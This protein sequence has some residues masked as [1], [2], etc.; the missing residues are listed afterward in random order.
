MK[1]KYHG[2]RLILLF[3][4]GSHSLYA[5]DTL[6]MRSL[7]ERVGQLQC[8]DSR[9]FPKGSIPCYRTYA[10]NKDRSKADI[11][12]FY[13][14]LTTFTLRNLKGQLTS[15]QQALCEQIINQTMPV[16][17]KFK[18]QKGRTTYNFWPTDTPQIFPHAGWI[19]FFDKA[20]SLPDDLDDTVIML[21][22][23]QAADSTAE[24][25]HALMQGYTNNGRKQIRN[26]F[27]D[28]RKIGAYSTW[29][30]KKM[31]VD[32][33][34][35]VLAN[36]LY[37][38]QSYDLA[39][40]SADSASLQLMVKILADK[41]HITHAAYVS[42]HYSRLPNI[43]YHISRLMQVKPIPELEA[44]KPALVEEALFALSA[45]NR[46][47]DAIILQTALL[48]WGV[49][50]TPSKLFETDHLFD[51]ME[52]QPF[53]FFIGD[54]ATMLPDPFKRWIIRTG[55]GKFYFESPGYNV[56]LVLENLVLHQQ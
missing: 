6:L 39:W 36:I 18:N 20:Q 45:S 8:T 14:G 52:E 1:Q 38:V 35:C 37:F 42:P 33:D 44:L 13:T 9:V 27:K 34:I 49:K 23:M 16:Y 56:A 54:I 29:V 7:L 24:Q 25:V 21:L 5:N 2:L 12:P 26:T 48:R 47:M 19:N 41:K 43:L 3:T 22:A 15:S 51:L 46:F 28:F 55:V 4:I 40:T 17:Q 53:A 50:P 10:L 11:N 32:F 31:P 30:G